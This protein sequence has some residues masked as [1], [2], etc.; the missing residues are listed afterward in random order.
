VDVPEGAGEGERA[1]EVGVGREEGHE[2][3]VRHGGGRER[4]KKI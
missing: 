1:R 4:S 3:I 2:R